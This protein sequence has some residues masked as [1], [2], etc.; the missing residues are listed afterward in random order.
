MPFGGWHPGFERSGDPSPDLQRI[1]ESLAA[2]RGTAYDTTT[3]T[4]RVAIE[5]QA[6]ARAIN[7]CWQNNQRMANQWI[8]MKMT[9]FLPRWETIYGIVPL[10]TDTL[11]DR[12]RRIAVIQLRSGSA[13]MQAVNDALV[14]LLGSI[15][16]GI[17]ITSSATANV[18]TPSTWPFGNHDATG[19]VDWYS[20][21]GYLAIKVAQ[22]AGMLDSDFYA[23]M[24]TIVPLLDAILPAW[25][26]FDW[27]RTSPTLGAGFY[28]DDTYNLDNE[29]FDV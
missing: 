21:V 28:L 5:L 8:A 15:F 13:N 1:F 10:S 3:L 17:T 6:Y 22:P 7:E 27:Y 16:V 11:I 23:T 20:T 29:A 26:T 2:A 24:G 19:A 14:T 18:W 25:V 4:G 12:R 9:D